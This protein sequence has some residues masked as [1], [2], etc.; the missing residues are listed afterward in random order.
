MLPTIESTDVPAAIRAAYPRQS[1]LVRRN[2]RD[3]VV[4]YF[5]PNGEVLRGGKVWPLVR[6]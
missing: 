3:G 4:E 2:E 5:G 1:Y 6:V